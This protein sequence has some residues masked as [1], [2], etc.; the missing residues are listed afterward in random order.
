MLVFLA[1]TIT[2]GFTPL[3]RRAIF[4]LT[5]L[6]YFESESDQYKSI[7]CF[8]SGA[9]LADV[10]LMLR[11]HGPQGLHRVSR[12]TPHWFDVVSAH[13]PVA[14][15]L[16]A[17]LLGSSP[18]QDQDFAFYSRAIW[19]FFYE[20]IVPVGGIRNVPTFPDRR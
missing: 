12:N 1:L 6:Y 7:F 5:T 18:P 14:L 9:L 2:A 3:W 15:F 4:I 13:W 10:S 20:R 17:L 16:F 19:F 8:F 11:G